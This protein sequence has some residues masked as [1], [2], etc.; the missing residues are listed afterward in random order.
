MQISNDLNSTNGCRLGDCPHH[1]SPGAEIGS[2]F[3]AC[4]V[5]YWIQLSVWKTDVSISVDC[6]FERRFSIVIHDRRYTPVTILILH[7]GR[8]RAKVLGT[9]PESIQ[10][11]NLWI[12]CVRRNTVDAQMTFKRH[13]LRSFTQAEYL[14]PI[15]HRKVDILIGSNLRM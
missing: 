5:V 4:E 15:P 11:S 9:S 10:R 13:V 14:G 1:A 12:I 3:V 6:R 7:K 2:T 8:L